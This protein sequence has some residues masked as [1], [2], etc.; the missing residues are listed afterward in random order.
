MG[1]KTGFFGVGKR[2]SDRGRI[3]AR[4]I[5]SVLFALLIIYF[6]VGFFGEA[7]TRSCQASSEENQAVPVEDKAFGVSCPPGF[8]RIPEGF[9]MGL[10]DRAFSVHFVDE[11]KGWI[12]GAFGLC[13]KTEDGGMGWQRVTIS[14]ED[15]F[16]DVFFVGESGWMVGERG[17]IFHTN[18]GGRSWKKQTT[19]VVQ[20]LLSVFFVDENKGFTVGGDGTI[21]KTGDAGSSWEIVDMEWMS[22]IPEA[23][24][25]IGVVSINLYEVFFPSETLGFIVGDSGTILRTTDGGKEWV[26]VQLADVP[27]IFSVYFKNDREGFAVG[28]HGYFLKTEDGGSSWNRQKIDTETS[29][30]RIRILGDY[31]VIVGDQATQFT[32]TDGGKTWVKS[33]NPLSPPYPWFAD[34]CI[35]PSSNS[36]HIVTVGKSIILNAGISK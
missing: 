18:D 23:L 2:K 3:K 9:M 7:R 29:L 21:L 31:G 25:D 8:C 19:D 24:M 27:P 20:A 11:K 26:L 4:K 13:L 6:L 35:V 22:I 36:G 30:Y 14:D 32:S 12:V 17:A 10:R 5:G 34:A 1:M 33:P 28:Y 15:S 16:K